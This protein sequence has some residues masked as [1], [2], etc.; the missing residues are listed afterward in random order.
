MLIYK[1]RES[2]RI[3]AADYEQSAI[4]TTVKTV[5]P[6]ASIARQCFL[7]TGPLAFLPLKNA[8]QSSI[9]WSTTH[10]HGKELMAF[11][12]QEFAEKLSE[13]FSYSLGA[14]T[15]VSK[16]YIFPLRM[17]HVKNY[18]RERL[19]LVGDAAHTIH[20]LAGQGVN[21]GLLDA[22]ALV[23]VIVTAQEKNRNFASLDTLRRYER[24]RKG[25]TV[26]ML[27]MVDFL[28]QLF[29]S[30][31]K[32]FKSMRYLGMGLTNQI[33]FLKNFFTRYALGERD[34]LPT[35]AE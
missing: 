5:L 32:F 28:N 22:V 13:A 6:H 21:L 10:D 26:A 11:S 1:G 8:H 19:A 24:A 31:K 12:D 17:R 3:Y 9:V 2:K 16:R 30:D 33:P 27:A 25:D 18:V 14:V 4:I 29:V 7:K 23:D 15:E 35:L 34:D 20:P